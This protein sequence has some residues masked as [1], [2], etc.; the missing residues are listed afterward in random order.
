MVEFRSRLSIELPDGWHASKESIQLLAPQAMANV[1]VSSED[2]GPLETTEEYVAAHDHALRTGFEG[3]REIAFGPA[4]VLGH[5]GYLRHFEWQPP[6]GVAITQLQAYLLHDG[7][8]Y[9]ATATAPTNNFPAVE[10]VLREVLQ[11][12]T[13]DEK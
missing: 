3:Y 1:I 2:I 11:R 4:I 5:Q 7:R 12:I 13:L 6:D 10:P 8:G 9:T